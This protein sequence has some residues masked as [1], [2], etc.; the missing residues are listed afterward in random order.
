MTDI[1][2]FLNPVQDTDMTIATSSMYGQ[3]VELMC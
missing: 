1:N 3:K 2:N